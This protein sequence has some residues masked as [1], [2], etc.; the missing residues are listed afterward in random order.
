MN[1]LA[2]QKNGSSVKVISR[3]RRSGK[4]TLALLSLKPKASDTLILMKKDKIHTLVEVV[5]T[6]SRVEP[7]LNYFT[8]LLNFAGIV[9]T[10]S[11][12]FTSFRTMQVSVFSTPSIDLKLFTTKS[13]KFSILFSTTLISISHSPAIM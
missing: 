6:L 3:V 10:L 4:S 13:P 2:R 8:T 7:F 5:D 11:V 12:S 1:I 9:G